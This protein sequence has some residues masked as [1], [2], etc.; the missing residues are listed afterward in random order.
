MDPVRGVGTVLLTARVYPEK[1]AQMSTVHAVRKAF[2]NA[3]KAV[4]T[5]CASDCG[6]VLCSCTPKDDSGSSGSQG[7]LD[8]ARDRAE[9]ASVLSIALACLLLLLCVATAC[10]WKRGAFSFFKQRLASD[11][12]MF[13]PPEGTHPDGSPHGARS[14]SLEMRGLRVQQPSGARRRA[15]STSASTDDAW[16]VS[17]T[18]HSSGGGGVGAVPVSMRQVTATGVPIASPSP[19]YAAP[20]A[21]RRSGGASPGPQAH[22]QAQQA[23]QLQQQ[24]HIGSSPSKVRGVGI[25]EVDMRVGFE[26]AASTRAYTQMS[27]AR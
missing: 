8:G 9:N 22:A 20:S 16:D 24:Q 4:V 12:A 15:S 13:L 25:G 11:S 14:T 21:S 1:F 23:P 3:V 10:F 6:T 19:Q 26:P 27:D 5:Q 18:T 7:V 2:N 17:L